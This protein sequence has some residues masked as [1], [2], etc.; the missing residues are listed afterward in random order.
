MINFVRTWRVG[1]GEKGGFREVFSRCRVPYFNTA[2]LLT[3][4]YRMKIANAIGTRLK[5]MPN[6]YIREIDGIIATLTL[7]GNTNIIFLNFPTSRA[8]R[9]THKLGATLGFQSVSF[10]HRLWHDGWTSSFGRCSFFVVR[11]S[12]L[13]GL[14]PIYKRFPHCEFI[15][16]V[17]YPNISGR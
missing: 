9:V 8:T 4:A 2:G 10:E 12:R 13:S 11:C 7:K 14:S 6:K 1:C 17:V 15:G 3:F 5:L 16:S